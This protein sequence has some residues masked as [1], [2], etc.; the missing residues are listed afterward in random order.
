SIE[1][2][3]RTLQAHPGECYFWATHTG[4]E[5]DLLH[6]RGRRRIGFEIKRSSSPGLTPSMRIAMKDLHLARL[7]VVHAGHERYP[8]ARNVEAVPLGMLAGAL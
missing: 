1:T 2:A 6:V 3:L 8:L 5:L 4:A 7:L